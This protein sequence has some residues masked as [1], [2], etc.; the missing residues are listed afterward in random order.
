M[1][2]SMTVLKHE[3]ITLVTRRSF[4]ITLLVLPL[5]SM[6]VFLFISYVNRDQEQS[7]VGNFFAPEIEATIDGYIDTA[8]IIISL[9]PNLEERLIAYEDEPA[10]EVALESGEIDGYYIISPDYLESGELVYIQSEY[11]PF[12]GLESADTLEYA[13]DYNL[14][15]QDLVLTE[16]VYSPYQLQRVSLDGQS[17]RDPDNMLTFFLPYIVTF[18]FYF[19]IFGSASLMLNS[20]TSEKQNRILEILM[21]SITPMEMLTGK[22]IALGLVGML[23][24][25]VWSATGLLVLRISGQTFELPAA[26]QLDISI[27]FWG[28]L[29]FLLGYAVYAS[30]MAGVGALV[31]NLKEASQATFVIMIPLIVPLMLVAPLISKPNSLLAVIISLFPLTAPVTMMTRLAA[32]A[33]PLWQILLAL[34][35]LLGTAYIIVRGVA[36]LFRAQT[37]LTGQKFSLKLLFQAL[38]GK[39]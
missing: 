29:F 31:P 22:M 10:A 12:S 14:L 3:F 17:D 1:K 27:L 39:A 36:G 38:I 13:L 26:F 18:L 24:T 20:V 30:L 15:G 8:G 37:L 19:V 11:S 16:R 33:V 23:Q 21:T 4:L 32:T 2:N 35:L 25:L 34:A 7:P 6:G 5:I 28:L 9:P